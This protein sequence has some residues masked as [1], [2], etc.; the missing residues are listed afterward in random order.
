M[1]S[2]KK[3]KRVLCCYSETWIV[4]Y[5][6]W[7]CRQILWKNNDALEKLELYQVCYQDLLDLVITED[8]NRIY[9]ISY[10]PPLGV[11]KQGHLT[12]SW[13]YELKTN[14]K[15]QD[16]V[17]HRPAYN[18]RKGD[19]DS[20]SRFLSELDWIQV[21]TGLSVNQMYDEFLFYYDFACKRFIPK[22][23]PNFNNKPW[24][25]RDLILNEKG[26]LKPGRYFWKVVVVLSKK[27]FIQETIVKKKIKDAVKT[28]ELQLAKNAKSN[29]KMF[30]NYVNRNRNLK[31]SIKGLKLEA[32][33][34]PICDPN[35]IATI[36]NKQFKM[37]FSDDSELTI[38][39]FINK[40]DVACDPDAINLI[41][42]ILRTTKPH[43]TKNPIERIRL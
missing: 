19:Y 40:T 12:L 38:P 20:F 17:I 32:S 4:H 11:V 5:R 28:F 2:K 37:A 36:L 8:Q 29:P 35:Q 30:Y 9:T 7:I 33:N 3:I 15:D 42:S 24:M 27:K 23:K 39:F 16:D 25:S 34:E 43:R 14:E 18:Y 10:G 1:L 26:S 21:F 6:N 22:R 41:H 31:S 13:N